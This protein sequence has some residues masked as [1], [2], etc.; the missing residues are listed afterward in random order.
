[1]IKAFSTQR[2]GEKWV[3][4]NSPR[5]QSPREQKLNDF[6]NGKNFSSNKNKTA[7]TN[8][9]LF[10]YNPSIKRTFGETKTSRRMGAE[11]DE[12]EYLQSLQEVKDLNR[13]A[14][15]FAK[16][17]NIRP[18]IFQRKLNVEPGFMLIK[19]QDKT[20]DRPV[21]NVP[22]ALRRPGSA[23]GNKYN[24]KCISTIPM[25]PIALGLTQQGRNRRLPQKP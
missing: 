8:Y 19:K 2:H 3:S 12:Y 16:G 17:S 5:G 23:L 14:H 13:V 11:Q 21:T 4:S 24:R 1:M 9:S 25:K 18:M 7:I 6:A 22:L 10:S 15:N 20:Y